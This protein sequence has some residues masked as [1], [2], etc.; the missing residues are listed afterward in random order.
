MTTDRLE[1]FSDGVFAIA[2]T[3]LVLELDVPTDTHGDLWRAL[4]EQWP[5]YLAY[6]I[7]FAVIGIIW[8]N[9]HGILALLHAWIGRCCI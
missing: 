5:S 2:I 4:L 6:L 8:V 9:H 1:T 7:S 3:L